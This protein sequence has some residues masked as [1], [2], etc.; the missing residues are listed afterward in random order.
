MR[1]RS[2]CNVLRM[3]LQMQGSRTSRAK[4]VVSLSGDKLSTNAVNRQLWPMNK[5]SMNK[6]FSGTHF[7]TM[8]LEHF[9]GNTK[10]LM[11]ITT[12]VAE[13]KISIWQLLPLRL[14]T[15]RHIF[16]EHI[17]NLTH[18]GLKRINILSCCPPC[19]GAFGIS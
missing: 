10:S 14:L 6:L 4:S 9:S 17:S 19:V 8:C 3:S 11:S 18:H 2:L 7:R 13:L 5:I 16:G 1:L 15:D 12:V